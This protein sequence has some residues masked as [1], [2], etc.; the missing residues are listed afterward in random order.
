MTDAGIASMP[1]GLIRFRVVTARLSPTIH[2]ALRT[3][4]ASL[5]ARFGARLREVVLF[6]SRARGEAHEESDVDVLVVVDDLDEHERIEVF[7]LA[8]DAG[9]AG[10]D[11]LSIAPLPYSTSQATELRARERRLMREIAQH[12][13]PL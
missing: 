11:Y 1:R 12:G 6:G 9:S 13:V 10:D 2:A 4:R 8:Y 7:D 5:D 3:F